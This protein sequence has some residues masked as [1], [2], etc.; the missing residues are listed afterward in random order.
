MKKNTKN[1]LTSQTM[2]KEN[3]L[4]SERRYFLKKAAY[5]APGLIALGQLIKPVNAKA[6]SGIGEIP[7]WGG[8]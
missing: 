4:K 8:W 3:N 5:S 1:K 6:D 2:N 7:T